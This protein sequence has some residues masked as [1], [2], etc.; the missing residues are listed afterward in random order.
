MLE[1]SLACRKPCNYSRHV[2]NYTDLL[3]AETLGRMQASHS[4]TPQDGGY[5]KHSPVLH[6][7]HTEK[8]Q[9]RLNDTVPCRS[10]GPKQR[11]PSHTHTRA[12]RETTN[13]SHELLSLLTAD[14]F[15]RLITMA[16][17][18][19]AHPKQSTLTIQH[20]SIGV[21]GHSKR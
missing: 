17:A 11:N 3:A 21:A 19:A 13:G 12:L 6:T 9:Q 15:G 16:A 5:T 8:G 1:T 4:R 7:A 2:T 14:K 18:E 20:E 10:R